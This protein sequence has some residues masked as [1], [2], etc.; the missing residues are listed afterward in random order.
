[1]QHLNMLPCLI[2]L[3]FA[4]LAHCQSCYYPDGSIAV[5]DTPCSSATGTVCCGPGFACLENR[6][7]QVTTEAQEADPDLNKNIL[8]IRGSCSDQT[9]A[10]PD[11]PSFCLGEQ[12]MVAFVT[13]VA[14][15]LTDTLSQTTWMEAIP[16]TTARSTFFA[17]SAETAAARPATTLPLSIWRR[18][19]QL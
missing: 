1:M 19:N 8:Y 13:T 16:W 3:A 12:C 15:Y 17:V 11:C 9:W 2:F 18:M 14:M 6:V 10:S 5:N 4:R 7:C